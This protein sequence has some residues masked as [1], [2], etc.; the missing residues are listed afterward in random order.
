MLREGGEMSLVSLK[1]GE[2]SLVMRREI[3]VRGLARGR[4][5]FR[6]HDHLLGDAGLRL[7]TAS[8]VGAESL[9]E[10]WAWWTTRGAAAGRPP[11][12]QYKVR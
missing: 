7:Q 5:G 4:T 9:P 8:E 12:M 3:R 2:M 11:G 1:G 6:S 10:T